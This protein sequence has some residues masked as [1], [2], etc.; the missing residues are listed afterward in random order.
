MLGHQIRGQQVLSLLS[1]DLRPR[2]VNALQAIR[3]RFK[4]GC[5]TNNIK[6]Q[7]EGPGMARD[8]ERA[9]RF[10]QVMDLFDVVIES[11]KIGIRKP[12]PEIYRIACRQMQISPDEAVF[13]DDLGINLKPARDLGM[14]T[15]KVLD[16]DLAL[17][18]LGE[19]LQMEF[20]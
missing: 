17:T 19:H 7:G 10:A 14:K 9:G 11:S 6:S 8:G 4:T 12:N 20:T 2:M 1:G 18:E 3:E 15:I 16:P 5:I 13:L